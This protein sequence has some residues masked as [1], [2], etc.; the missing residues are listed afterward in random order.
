MTRKIKELKEVEER[1]YVPICVEKDL[2]E[3]MFYCCVESG[4]NMGD[5]VDYGLRFLL[6]NY[7]DK[8]NERY[9]MMTPDE[10]QTIYPEMDKQ[11]AMKVIE[12]AKEDNL[13]IVKPI[14]KGSGYEQGVTSVIGERMCES[15]KRIMEQQYNYNE[16]LKL[17]TNEEIASRYCDDDE[18]DCDCCCDHHIEALPASQPI[19]L[20]DLGRLINSAHNVNIYVQV[21]PEE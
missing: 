5:V 12:L 10:I 17:P 3:N 13:A 4:V 14:E 19:G 21:L 6:S 15:C 7:I 20:P 1:E 9:A 8:R 16:R 11:T 18:E 2:A